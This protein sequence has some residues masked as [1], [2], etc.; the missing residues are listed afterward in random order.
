[1][2]VD[3]IREKELSRIVSRNSPLEID[4][5]YTANYESIEIESERLIANIT[6]SA[7]HLEIK[8][9]GSIFIRAVNCYLALNTPSQLFVSY[10]I[11]RLV[12]RALLFFFILR[13]PYKSV[14]A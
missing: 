4:G 3:T 7:R 9:L 11:H 14:E 8:V 13:R 6:T 12:L 5:P 1:M 2:S 10:Q